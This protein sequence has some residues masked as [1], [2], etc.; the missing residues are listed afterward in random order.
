MSEL[1]ASLLVRRTRLLLRCYPKAYRASR[2]EE[3]LD[4]LLETTRPGRDWPPAREMASLVG[5]GLRARKA[6]NLSQGVGATLRQGAALG[7][8]VFMIDFYLM[9]SGAEFYQDGALKSLVQ[10]LPGAL[11]LVVTAGVWLGRRRLVAVPYTAAFAVAITLFAVTRS[12]T[13]GSQ[14]LLLGIFGVLALAVL[15]PLT[16]RD[17]RPPRSLL[18]FACVP[19]GA[20]MVEGALGRVL[21]HFHDSLPP[22]YA[23]VA[24]GPFRFYDSY[25]SL[26]TVAVAVCWLV[27]DI[28]PL[29]GLIIG[30][31]L[32][33]I[34]M[35]S[36]EIRSGGYLYYLYLTDQLT[37]VAIL[38]TVA[39]ALVW[40]QRRRNSAIPPAA[41]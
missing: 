31:V 5:G 34:V 4:T 37:E 3:I 29:L 13:V 17:A 12:E 41:G 39:A 23:F 21:P 6:A 19:V 16:K 28:R 26:V 2:G 24:S 32:P 30:F 40:L 8:I 22:F 35:Y 38:I 14:M 36:L 7:V 10:S 1:D 15:T 20:A 27:T 9:L 25:L 11:I 33:A 18:W